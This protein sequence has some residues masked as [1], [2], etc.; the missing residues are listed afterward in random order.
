MVHWVYHVSWELSSDPPGP[1]GHLTWLTLSFG[2]FCLWRGC[3]RE[4]IAQKQS[5]ISISLLVT[6][7]SCGI[8]AVAWAVGLWGC[9]AGE[10]STN[11]L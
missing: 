10:P 4:Q 3:S 7:V 11:L 5:L 8:L 6:G 1:F 2:P 9:G